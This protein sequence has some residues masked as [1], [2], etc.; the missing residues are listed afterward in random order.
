[1][2]VLKAQ[3]MSIY[4]ADLAMPFLDRSRGIILSGRGPIWLYG[5]LVHECHS[6]PFVAIYDPRLDGAIIVERHIVNAPVVGEYN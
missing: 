4:L 5:Y 6:H 1:M 2:F 3:I